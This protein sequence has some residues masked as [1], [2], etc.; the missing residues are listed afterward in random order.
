MNGTCAPLPFPGKH[1]SNVL[2][3]GPS[4][5]IVSVRNSYLIC[6]VVI[7]IVFLLPRVTVR[8]IWF[9]CVIQLLYTTQCERVRPYLGGRQGGSGYAAVILLEI[10]VDG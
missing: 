5:S 8:V 6:W 10:K 1:P 9:S 2:P 7:G 3:R 4:K